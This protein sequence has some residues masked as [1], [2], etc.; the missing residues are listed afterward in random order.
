MSNDGISAEQ[1]KYMNRMMN[2]GH[3]GQPVNLSIKAFKR[4]IDSEFPG[5]KKSDKSYL[6]KKYKTEAWSDY[7]EVVKFKLAEPTRR[8][9]A[10]EKNGK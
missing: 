2:N 7:D 4:Y 3:V 6:I 9:H 1:L 8:A 10:K 5:I